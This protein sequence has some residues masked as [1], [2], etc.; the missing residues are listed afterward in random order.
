MYT[1]ASKK[2]MK[3][4]PS[5]VLF[6]STGLS[7]QLSH[8]DDYRASAVNQR[9]LAQSLPRTAAGRHSRELRLHI[10]RSSRA[11][12][13]RKTLAAVFGHGILQRKECPEEDTIQRYATYSKTDQNSGNALGWKHPD[14]IPL[15]IAEDGELGVSAKSGAWATASRRKNAENVLKK[16]YSS[17]KIEKGSRRIKGKAPANATGG[18]ITLDEVKL[19]NRVGGGRADLTADCGTAAREILGLNRKSDKFAAEYK[20]NTGKKL[21]ASDRYYGSE[22]T[23]TDNFA[24]HIFRKHFGLHLTNAQARARY[25]AL[26]NTGPGLTKDKFDRKY[27]I[28]KYAVPELGQAITSNEPGGW[29]FH[30]AGVI[31]KS[32]KDYITA[33]NIPGSGRGSQS[34]Y[35]MIYGPRSKAQTFHHKWK[36]G[37]TGKTTTMVVSSGPLMLLKKAIQNEDGPAIEQALKIA[38]ASSLP[39]RP[40]IENTDVGV[41]K[42]LYA[43]KESHTLR[44]LSILKSHYLNALP[45]TNR[46]NLVLNCAKGNTDDTE[47]KLIKTIMAASSTSDFSKI[48]QKVVTEI[49]SESDDIIVDY[50]K[51]NKGVITAGRVPSNLNT[52]QA[53]VLV[54]ALIH[55]SCTGDDELAVNLILESLSKKD[56]K[57]VVDKLTYNY[58]DSGLDG[59]SWD[60]FLAV[61]V[62]KYPKD[63]NLGIILI[64]REKND[65]A[66]RRLLKMEKNKNG[67]LP[68]NWIR[69]IEALLDGDCGDD[70]ED[71][72]L[73]IVKHLKTIGKHGLVHTMIGKSEMDSGVDGAQWRTLKMLMKDYNW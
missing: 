61:C 50:L 19:V 34:W 4:K 40:I 55:G 63:E 31:L 66:A 15:K 52:K 22:P 25:K 65:D 47:T 24:D 33:E 7:I 49:P 1:T 11:T 53:I 12:A 72:I 44:I 14:Q 56:F 38:V 70:D 71:A 20:T 45:Y 5:R 37:V 32:S 43:A 59:E 62:M 9:R 27:G 60:R 29:N 48:I 69:V 8:I 21:T 2:R 73:E 35:Y 41:K 68:V 18:D 17:V 3:R 57:T 13:Q 30:F 67:I 10:H 42:M 23:C 39:L 54:K 6:A 36:S 58:I 51:N 16:N 46:E 28:N 64:H 26:P